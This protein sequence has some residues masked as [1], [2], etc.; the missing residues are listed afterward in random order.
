MGN[1]QIHDVENID[2]EIGA[3]DE[4]R[5]SKRRHWP[6]TEYAAADFGGT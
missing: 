5:Q 3:E 2:T 1:N 4:P 6:N